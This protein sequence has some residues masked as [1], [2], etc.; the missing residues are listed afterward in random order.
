[1]IAINYRIDDL[2]NGYKHALTHCPFTDPAKRGAVTPKVSSQA[3]EE[4]PH[5]VANDRLRQI[6]VCDQP[7]EKAVFNKKDRALNPQKKNK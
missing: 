2:G 6:L 4:C 3:C 1:M 7:A 5:F